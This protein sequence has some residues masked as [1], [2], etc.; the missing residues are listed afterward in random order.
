M[1]Y[2]VLPLVLC[3]QCVTAELGKL[4]TS[5]SACS[6]FE[7]CRLGT[8]GRVTRGYC[9]PNNPFNYW[10][11]WLTLIAGM[12]TLFSVVTQCWFAGEI[13]RLFDK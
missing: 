12:V 4:C 2:S 7:E 11:F 9:E 3:V 10:W 6:V 1:L 13:K 8:D 5:S